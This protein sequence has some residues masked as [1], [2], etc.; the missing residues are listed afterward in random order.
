MDQIKNEKEE[1]IIKIRDLHFSYPS[2]YEALKG[3]NLN[4]FKGEVLAIIGRNGAGKTTLVKHF[5]G[6]LKATSGEVLVNGLNAKEHA[7]SRL[8]KIV[9]YVFQNPADQIFSSNLWD[10][11]AF[12]PKNL[13]FSK[14]E[15]D[16]NVENSLKMVGLLNKKDTHPY[17]LIFSERKLLCIASVLAM[18]PQV[19]II[20]EPETG[21]DYWGIKKLIEIIKEYESI[22]RSIVLIS[23]N[24][25]LVAECAERVIVMNDGKIVG[26]TFT[27]DILSNIEMLSKARLKPPQI[28]RLTLGL[29]KWNVPKELITVR[30]LAKY[31]SGL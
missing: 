9:G 12:G 6:L 15:I 20:D 27:P 23:H 14:E 7:V 29:S 25:A 1:P 8:A 26:D 19:I 3:I 31:L 22:Q 5:N 2:G 4:I 13:R 16:S 17:D 21:Q 24:L 30:K 10:E 11:V 28:I 18:D